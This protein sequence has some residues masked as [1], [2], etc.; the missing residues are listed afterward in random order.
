MTRLRQGMYRRTPTAICTPRCSTPRR[1]KRSNGIVRAP[2]PSAQRGCGIS[3]LWCAPSA[4]RHTRRTRPR[5]SFAPS[6]SAMFATTATARYTTCRTRTSYGRAL[7]RTRRTSSSQRRARRRRRRRRTRTRRRR[8]RDSAWLA[9]AMTMTMA[10]PHSQMR[11][12]VVVK[13]SRCLTKLTCGRTTAQVARAEQA[14]RRRL[15]GLCQLPGWRYRRQPE[16]QP[17]PWLPRRLRQSQRCGPRSTA[18]HSLREPASRRPS[19]RLSLPPTLTRT[20][21]MRPPPWEAGKARRRPHQTTSSSSAT[22]ARSS[23]CGR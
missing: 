22:M 23:T 19:S 15:Q 13:L 21:A 14:G 3:T 9:M 7:Q 12:L 17:P 20:T 16:R 6:A 2:L 4:T 11:T 18:A 10:R 1:S 8:M 5:P